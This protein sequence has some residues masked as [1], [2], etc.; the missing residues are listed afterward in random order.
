MSSPSHF[1][2]LPVCDKRQSQSAQKLPQPGG[3][4]AEV[5]TKSGEDGIGCVAVAA[6][7]V[8]AV[9]AVIIF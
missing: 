2:T 8:V 9:H 6:D 4:A 5:V 7:Q 1:G 3:E